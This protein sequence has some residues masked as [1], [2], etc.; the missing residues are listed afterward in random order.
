MAHLVCGFASG[1]SLD[2]CFR[3][4]WALATTEQTEIDLPGRL[5]AEKDPVRRFSAVMAEIAESMGKRHA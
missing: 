3:H 2:P 5:V 1:S 4:L